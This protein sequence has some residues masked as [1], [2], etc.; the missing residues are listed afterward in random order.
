LLDLVAYGGFNELFLVVIEIVDLAT[1]M[2]YL[3]SSTVGRITHIRD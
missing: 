2:A 1:A 3:A